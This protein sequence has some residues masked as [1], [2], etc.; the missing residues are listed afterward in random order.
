MRNAAAIA[1]MCGYLLCTA[2]T[3]GCGGAHTAVAT[4][5]S[6]P[7][8]ATSF[9][10]GLRPS[11]L[12]GVDEA[13]MSALAAAGYNIVD[14]ASDVVVDVTANA[15]ESPSFFQMRVNGVVKKNYRIRVTVSLRWS[16]RIIDRFSA[17]FSGDPASVSPDDLTDL[18]SQL[19]GSS[20]VRK[21]IAEYE[22]NAK[23]VAAKQAAEVRAQAE[24]DAIVA[25]EAEA[26]REEEEAHFARM[27]MTC[28]SPANGKSCD[29]LRAWL[30]ESKESERT[31]DGRISDSDAKRNAHWRLRAQS[32]L[33]ASESAIHGHQD[34]EAWAR[35]NAIGCKAGNDCAD[36]QNYIRQFA[37]GKHITEAKAAL[38]ER[39]RIA[40][41]R[42]EAEERQARAQ[43]QA[44][45]RQARAQEQAN[46]TRARASACRSNCSTN[47]CSAYFSEPKKSACVSDCM[48]ECNK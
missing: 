8:G 17:E 38:G 5:P 29:P 9:D 19:N 41:A 46:Q 15:V 24:R 18:V 33:N 4:S 26:A 3:V 20:R 14:G 13:L 34:D 22:A 40:N 16:D 42:A 12:Q 36:V 45:E 6:A 28:G 2:V 39:D 30:K 31:E 47:T 25:A 1:T 37:D 11:K 48:A 27:I 44:E 7:M 43:E 35:A 32:T 21:F 10:L 23:D